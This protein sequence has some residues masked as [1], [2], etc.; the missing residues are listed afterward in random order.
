MI[1]ST[2]PKRIRR[3]ET[4]TDLS[5]GSDV[6]PSPFD[7][8]SFALFFRLIELYQVAA[9]IIEYRFDPPFGLNRFSLE[10]NT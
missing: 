7:G 10:H 1:G 2:S 9:R 4:T 8:V 3:G 5:G 6:T